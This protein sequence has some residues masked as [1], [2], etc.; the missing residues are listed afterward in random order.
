M[1][2]LSYLYLVNF[3][4][5]CVDMSD[6]EQSQQIDPSKLIHGRRA[7]THS[8]IQERQRRHIPK[9]GRGR[10][11][12]RTDGEGSSHA[13]QLEESHVVDPSQVEYLNYQDEV[14]H[15]V[16]DGGYDQQHIP[17]QQHIPTRVTLQ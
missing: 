2:G 9:R 8:A 13:T 7:M 14:H 4:N 16:T 11:K 6:H 12:G 5:Y 15:D 17:E 1:F 10:G 3:L